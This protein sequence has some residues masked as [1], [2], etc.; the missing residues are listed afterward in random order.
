[1]AIQHIAMVPSQAAQNLPLKY[2]LALSF[3]IFSVTSIRIFLSPSKI[4]NES[5]LAGVHRL[6]DSM[7]PNQLRR[8]FGRVNIISISQSPANIEIGFSRR[9]GK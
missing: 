7:G 2:N 1:M 4:H 6:G 9:F 5:G 3:F 8:L